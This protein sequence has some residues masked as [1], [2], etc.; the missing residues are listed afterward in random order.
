MALGSYDA[1]G[2]WHYGES[3]NIA[4]FSDTLNKLADSTTSAFTSDRARIGTLEAGS[5]A[6][7]I[8]V[9]PSSVTFVGGTGTVN[10]L[11]QVTFANCTGVLVQNCFNS[12]F[13]NYRIVFEGFKGSLTGNHTV[14]MR[15][16]SG[17]ATNTATSYEAGALGWQVNDGAGQQLGGG[18]VT[19]FYFNR[20][21][22]AAVPFSTSIDVFT[23][24]EAKFTRI[25]GTAMGRTDGQGQ[26][27]LINGM[28]WVGSS[29]DGFALEITGS[30]FNGTFSVYGYND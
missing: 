11:G 15:M 13:K 6:G 8:P 22:T 4:L 18:S 14:I 23:P 12:N 3:D 29:F 17:G 1:N 27:I 2:I 19:Y 25:S 21:Y 10:T 9:K 28:H 24:Y 30:N 26:S 20:A 16:A 7:L 5:L